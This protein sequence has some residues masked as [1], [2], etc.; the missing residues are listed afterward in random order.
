MIIGLTGKNASGKGEFANYLK[1]KGFVYFSL[2][3]VVREEATKLGLEHS[4]DN[5]IKLGNELRQNH[6]SNYLAQKIN[7]KIKEQLKNNNK[8]FAIDS[9]RSPYEAKELMKNENFTLVGIEA[10]IK[11]R[12]ERLRRRNRIGDAK[13]LEEFKRQEERENLNNAANQQLDETFK[14]AEKIIVNDR[15]FEE[16]HKKIDSLLDQIQKQ[17]G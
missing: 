15:T 2:S 10:P 13:T 12:F 4:R 8:N 14:L 11:L 17:W 7:N 16:L 9:I 1:T 3:D 6:G 5:L